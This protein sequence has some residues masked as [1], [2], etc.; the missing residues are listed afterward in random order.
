[1]TTYDD[2]TRTDLDRIARRLTAPASVCADAGSCARADAV[3]LLGDLRR[4][5]LALALARGRYADLHAAA[6]A[7][8]GAHRDGEPDPLAYLR[9]QLDEAADAD[10]LAAVGSGWGAG[11]D[12]PIPY[13][14]TA[15]ARRA[16]RAGS[17]RPGG[18]AA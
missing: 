10:A 13:L 3:A 6:R 4:T 15:R 8:L 18:D 12:L 1:M 9:D 7:T 17:R 2:L 16:E 5:R 14:P 11:A